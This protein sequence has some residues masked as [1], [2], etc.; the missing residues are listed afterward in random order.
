MSGL[1]IAALYGIKP[2]T[3]GFCG[4]QEKSASRLILSYLSGKKISG[5]KIRKIFEKFE[6]AYSYYKLIAKANKIKDPFDERVVMAYWIGNSLL[7]KV[8]TRKLREMIIR[9][10]SRP[11]LL[12]KKL[13]KEKAEKIPK[14]AKPHHSFH[15]LVIGSVT[16]RVKLQGKL[17]D[18]CRVSWGKITKIDPR[19][20]RIKVKYR[21]LT[22]GKKYRLG[23]TK[24]K[25][26]TWNKD[27]LPNLKIGQYISFHWNQAVQILIKKDL[28]NI[29]KY[30]KKTLD[31]F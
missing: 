30:T 9:K 11:G 10:F 22:I 25:Y 29:Q 15:V 24:E 19:K 17:L 20:G 13:A 23:K 21:P 2:H 8:S 3:L 14:G 4:P 18:F 28:A 1:K 27:L 12:S 7:D 31:C 26:I 6:G 5:K 16:H